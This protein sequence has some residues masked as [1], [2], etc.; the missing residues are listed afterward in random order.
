MPGPVTLFVP[1]YNGIRYLGQ[2]LEQL[3]GQDYPDFELI[4]VDNVS[5]D[6][7]LE[8]AQQIEDPR[9]VVKSFSEHVPLYENFNRCLRLVNTPYFAICP[10]DEVYEPY[11]LGRMVTLLEGHPPALLACCKV[12][13]ADANGRVYLA[14]EERFKDL[15][16]NPEEPAIFTPKRDYRTLIKGNYFIISSAL[17]RSEFAQQVGEFNTEITYVG[18]WEFFLRGFTLG[19]DIV[20]THQRLVHY[21]RHAN[22]TTVALRRGLVRYRQWVDV[23]E[24][25]TDLGHERGLLASSR[26]DYVFLKAALVGLMASELAEGSH[27][28]PLEIR[29]FLDET[30]PQRVSLLERAFFTLAS[31]AGRPGGKALLLAKRFFLHAQTTLYRL[32]YKR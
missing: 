1:N 2:T 3:L 31:L 14:P 22:M 6:G 12:D 23:V 19:Y 25:M 20:G 18:D 4:V 28:A 7:S 13:S 29:C 5:T 32:R 24:R 11:W 17:F 10:N 9:L 26:R 21:R 27:Q 8:L 30:L 16:W 15:C